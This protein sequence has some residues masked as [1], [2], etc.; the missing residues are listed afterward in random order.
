MRGQAVDT[1]K[2]FKFRFKM[3][4]VL[5]PGTLYTSGIYSVYFD[6]ILH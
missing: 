3:N 4:M 1:Q 2:N 5:F 6:K